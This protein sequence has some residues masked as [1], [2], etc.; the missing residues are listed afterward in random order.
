MKKVIVMMAI[1]AVAFT[2]C[3]KENGNTSNSETEQLVSNQRIVSLNGAVTEVL[4]K[5]GVANQIV[6][7]D[8]TSTYPENIKETAQDLGHVK[9][10]AVE[11]ILQLKPTLVIGTSTDFEPEMEEQLKN[12]GVET[13]IIDQEFTVDGTKKLI[14]SVSEKMNFKSTQ[15]LF[16]SIDNQIASVKIS[17]NKPKVLFIYARGAGMLMVAGKGTQ[18]HNIIELAGGENAAAAIEDFKPLTPEALLTNNPDVILMF[19]KGLESVGGIDGVLKI[20]GIEATNAGKNKKIISMDGQ[21]LSGF[22]PR[23]GEA[24]VELNK[25]LQ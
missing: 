10:I 16:D 25:L 17:E 7:V 8:V 6:G 22:G 12:A 24:V 15:E 2:N 9:K 3:K 18:L 11:A 20:E 19:D 21:F 14:A 5:I 4:A 13:L 1:A 23:L